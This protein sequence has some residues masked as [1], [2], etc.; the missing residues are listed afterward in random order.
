MG[1]LSSHCFLVYR[2]ERRL[3]LFRLDLRDLNGVRAL[4]ALANLE[5]HLVAYLESIELNINELVGVEKEILSHSLDLDESETLVRKAGNS[6]FLHA[7]VKQRTLNKS[8]KAGGSDEESTSFLRQALRLIAAL[9]HEI[10][11]EDS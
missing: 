9:Y 2:K 10:P 6:S 4:G 11:P 7:G 3:A 1:I 8:I 5:F